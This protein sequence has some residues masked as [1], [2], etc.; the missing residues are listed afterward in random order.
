MST[1][2]AALSDELEA[3]NSIYD[4]T[5]LEITPL[6]PA[7]PNTPAI[8]TLPHVP[9]SFH[10]TFPPTYPHDPPTIDG[11]QSTGAQTR[12]GDGE[13]TL[14]VLRTV[15]SQI[16][17]TGQ[18]CLFDLIEESG[19]LL[20]AAAPHDGPAQDPAGAARRCASPSPP[21]GP[22]CL[23]IDVRR[24]LRPR[25]LPCA[26]HRGPHAPAGYEQEGRGCHAQ[27]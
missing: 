1:D 21:P 13:A 20:H 7:T 25:L 19:P 12:K 2:N 4:T 9:S 18:E 16:F 11:T 14:T 5:T 23:E 27:C 17:T 22:G 10:L 8:L 15:L 26:R 24:A 3:L 6:S